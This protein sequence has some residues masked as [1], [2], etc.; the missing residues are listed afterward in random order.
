MQKNKRPAAKGSTSTRTDSS[1]SDANEIAR[2][3][4]AHQAKIDEL[5]AYGLAEM[6]AKVSAQIKVFVASVKKWDATR[7]RSKGAKEGAVERK[8]KLPTPA[9]LRTQANNLLSTGTAT[10][11]IAAKL[12]ARYRVT[13]RAIRD[14]L[15]KTEVR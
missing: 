10:H 12:G 1:D 5:N 11:E 13:S 8:S 4:Q 2:L 7:K 15:K 14:A 6:R 3:K 9:K